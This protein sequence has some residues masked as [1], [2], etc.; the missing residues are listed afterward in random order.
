VLRATV[1]STE[2]HEYVQRQKPID[3]AKAV[4]I[5]GIIADTSSTF[6]SDVKWG[7]DTLQPFV[8][9]IREVSWVCFPNWKLC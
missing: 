7:V 4:E 3:K 1:N 9:A 8:S 2:Y 6:F 5:K